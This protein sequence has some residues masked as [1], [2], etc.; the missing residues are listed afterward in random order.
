MSD[1]KVEEMRARQQ[2]LGEDFANLD[3][4]Y[5]LAKLDEAHERIGTILRVNT[6]ALTAAEERER[7]LIAALRQ[8]LECPCDIGPEARAIL[9][10]LLSGT[11][12]E[13][14]KSRDV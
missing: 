7:A 13:E 1:P 10:R 11:P 12:T 14:G 4:T 3:I 9:S 6:E 2:R 8:V 5:L